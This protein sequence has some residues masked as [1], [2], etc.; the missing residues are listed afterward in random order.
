MHRGAIGRVW[1]FLPVTIRDA[2][3]LTQKLGMRYLW[4]GS[5]CVLQNDDEDRERGVGAMDHIYERAWL[6]VIAAC[7]H[8]ANAGLPGVQSGS[9]AEL[10]LA[11]EVCPGFSM[12]AYI[13]IEN[14]LMTSVYDTRAW[15][16]VRKMA[17]FKSLIRLSTVFKRSNCLDEHC[18]S[19]TTRSSSIAVRLSLQR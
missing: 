10:P 19:S 5:I 6:T 1:K 15:T 2:I 13:A 12:G 18:I 11:R 14:L 9:R 17:P 7:G 16:Y 3:T 8:D 4:V